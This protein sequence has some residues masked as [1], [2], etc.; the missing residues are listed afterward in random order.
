MIFA[1]N[2]YLLIAFFVPSLQN[3][4]WSFT[5]ALNHCAKH[6]KGHFVIGMLLAKL[7]SED[8]LGS[9]EYCKVNCQS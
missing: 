7:D 4:I 8:E 2:K 1:D 6:A 9:P 3:Y 5:V